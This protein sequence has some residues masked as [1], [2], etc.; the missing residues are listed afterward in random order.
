[1]RN[2]FKIKILHIIFAAFL[3][4]LNEACAEN[5]DAKTVSHRLATIE[6]EELPLPYND[7]LLSRIKT[8]SAKSLPTAFGDYDSLFVAELKERNMPLELE[9]LPLALS[10][11]QLDWQRGDRCG[12]WALPTLVALHHGLT[13][14]EKHDERFAVEDATAVALDYLSDLYRQNGDWWLALLA[15]VNSPMALNKALSQTVTTPAVWDFYEMDLV[16]DAEVIGDFI[17][18]YYVYSS[19]HRTSLP[20]QG[21]NVYVSFTGPVP[22]KELAKKANMTESLIKALNP[23]FRSDPMEPL[24]GQELLLPLKQAKYFP[25]IENELY[26]EGVAML[27]KPVKPKKEKPIQTV[28]ST[29]TQKKYTVKRG[30]TLSGIAKKNHVKVSDI[31]RWN[32]LKSDKIREGQKLIIKI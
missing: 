25:V 26:E 23:V 28:T 22:V 1:M 10:N 12:V 14:D 20:S 11:M 3:V 32:K 8:F 29:S 5:I 6:S 13:V 16:P 4:F 7:V 9:Y 15:Y 30:D 17:A 2:I 27:S 18:C 31:K 24:E 19:A 21:K